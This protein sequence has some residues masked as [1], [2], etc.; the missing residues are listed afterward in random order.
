VRESL[1]KQRGIGQGL[2]NIKMRAKTINAIVHFTLM[3]DTFI[4]EVS[5]VPKKKLWNKSENET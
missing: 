2:R 3:G 1:E 5:S 4:V